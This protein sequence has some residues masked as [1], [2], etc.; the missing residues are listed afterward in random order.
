MLAIAIALLTVQSAFA[1]YNPQV[2]RWANRDPMGE[3]GGINLYGF[4]AND[5]L[6]LTDTDGRDWWPPSK[7]PKW[8][9]SKP[10]PPTPPPPSPKGPPTPSGCPGFESQ[11]PK[12]PCDTLKSLPNATKNTSLPGTGKAGKGAACLFL[13]AECDKGC[14]REYGPASMN[15]YNNAQNAACLKDCKQQCASEAKQCMG[16]II[17]K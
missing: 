16:D 4:V 11:W 2:G 15:D 17:L 6:I 5:P 9:K 14:G 13:K 8:P 10:K 7:W 3:I 1:F 12:D